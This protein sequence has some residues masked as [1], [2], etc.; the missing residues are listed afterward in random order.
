MQNSVWQFLGELEKK[1][2]ITEIIINDP[3][4]IFI[5][6][7]GELIKLD[8]QINP[9]DIPV[10]L[11]DVAKQNR[12]SFDHLNPV[13]DAVLPD[14]SRINAIS[15][16]YTGNTS[17]ITI[18]KYLKIISHF[19]KNPYV[20]GASPK[21]VKLLK[22]MVK[23]KFNI[24]VSGGTGVGKTSL[25]NLLIQEIPKPERVITIEDTK[26][27]NFDLPNC[28]RL[29]C[30]GQVNSETPHLTLKELIKN[31][32]RM[33]PDRIIIGEVRGPEVFDMLQAMNTGH[34][35]SL[36]SVHSNSTSECIKRLE[37]LFLLAGYDVPIR[38][39]RAQL[40]SA[41]D[42]VIQLKRTREGKRVISKIS[43]VT[44]IEGE[45]LLLQDIAE[46]KNGQLELTRFTPK[47][48]QRLV[49][50]GLPK[51]FFV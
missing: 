49:D 37:T 24:I 22:A 42:F 44:G 15:G 8:Y 31:T 21:L 48:Y 38:S 29:E 23:G 32:L 18:R 14:G 28:V 13:L 43:E 1:A 39:I 46:Y 27:L 51:D 2:G 50:S 40:A 7:Q 47:C 19:D 26:E 17:A 41:L 33:R 12:R 9:Q 35:G 30:K 20:F 34:D 5:E 36:C 3:Q 11:A 16:D 4:N 6:F 45:M 10:F 25:L